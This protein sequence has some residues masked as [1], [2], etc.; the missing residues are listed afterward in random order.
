MQA[1]RGLTGLIATVATA[2]AIMTGPAL[3]TTVV[4]HGFNT[5]ATQHVTV[6]TVADTAPSDVTPDTYHDM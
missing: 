2:T 1:K 6:V 3:A 5:G 4:Y